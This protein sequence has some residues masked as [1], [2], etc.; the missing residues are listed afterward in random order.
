MKPDLRF[1]AFLAVGPNDPRWASRRW[2]ELLVKWNVHRSKAANER[3]LFAYD[4]P[5]TPKPITDVK[6]AHRFLEE[7]EDNRI[8]EKETPIKGPEDLV[9]AVRPAIAFWLFPVEAFGD[10]RGTRQRER[11]V[12]DMSDHWPELALS[13]LS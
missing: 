4:H 11:A 12:L 13:Y 5:P 2:Q 3:V 9:N 10:P 1:L 7:E 6:T 8:A